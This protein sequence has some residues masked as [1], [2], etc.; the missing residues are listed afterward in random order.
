MARKAFRVCKKAKSGQSMIEFLLGLICIVFLVAGLMQA[1][2]ISCENLK[3]ISLARED[4]ADLLTGNGSSEQG[5]YVYS[6]GHDEGNDQRR[7]TGDDVMLSGTASSFF[8]D[9]FSSA[10]YNE[11]PIAGGESIQQYL[12]DYEQVDPYAALES[13]GDL[14]NTYNMLFTQRS[15]DIEIVPVIRRLVGKGSFI[16][17]RGIWMPEL[18]GLMEP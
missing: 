15:T 2:E 1:R 11:P 17:S 12:E 6:E 16:L 4:V 10:R 8:S 13:T 18:D 14:G 7:F 9:F 3:M 5:D